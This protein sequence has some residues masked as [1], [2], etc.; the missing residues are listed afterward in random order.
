MHRLPALTANQV[1]TLTGTG[2]DEAVISSV[3]INGCTTAPTYVVQ[4]VTTLLLKT[5]VDCATSSTVV[6][7]LTD[8]SGNTAATVPGATGVAMALT[9]VAAPTIATMD[10]TTNPVVTENSQSV[11]Y[12]NQVTTASTKGGTVVRIKSGA[13]AFVNT[14]TYPLGASIDGVALTKVAMATGGGYLTGVVGAHAADAAPV[15]KVTSNGVS[16][17]FAYHVGGATASAG[18]QSF[19]YAGTGISIARPRA[20][21]TAACR[22]SSAARASRPAPR[23][24]SVASPAR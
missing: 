11:A 10:A 3:G 9:F 7:T 23:S 19:Q 13:T 24:P 14:T 1:I 12:A 15:V 8:T 21:S 18:E 4:N 16:K 6:I 17:S 2:F 22:S 20:R 5:A